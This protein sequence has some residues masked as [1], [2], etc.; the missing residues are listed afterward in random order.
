MYIDAIYNKDRD[1]V[2]IAERINGKRVMKDIPVEYT[3][4]YDDPNGSY[5]S[6]YGT[7][8]AKYVTRSAK[9][10][11]FEKRRLRMDGKHTYEADI[12][13]ELKILEQYYKEGDT[14]KPN[15]CFFDI[16]VDFCKKRGFAPTNDPFN[17]ITAI[18]AYNS[19]EKICYTVLLKP[20][21]MAESVAH[22]IASKFDNTMV[23]DDEEQLLTMFFGIIEDA[24]ILTGW[25]STAFDIPY[26][27]NRI[28]RI[29][30]SDHARELCLWGYQPKPRTFERFKKKQQT[31]DLVGR[32]HLDYLEDLYKKYTYHEQPS[33]KLDY[34]G[35]VEVGE[36][37]VDYKG[38]LDHLY[39]FDFEKFVQYSRQDV[40]LMVKIDDK[41]DHI[42]LVNQIAHDNLVR[43]QTVAGAVAL[44]DHAIVREI[45]SK[46]LVVRDKPM[47]T[48]SVFEIYDQD[49]ITSNI[50][51]EEL[52]EKLEQMNNTIA[53]AF[54]ADPKRGL[55]DW[56]GSTDINS[57]YPSVIRALN[58]SPETIFG[59]IDQPITRKHHI[60]IVVNEAEGKKNAEMAYAWSGKFGSQEFELMKEKSQ[61]K[62]H[63]DFED[64]TSY[65][66][67][68]DEIHSLVYDQGQPLCISANGTI[69]RTDIPGIIPGLLARWYNERVDMRKIGKSFG[70]M[71][72]GVKI[73]DENLLKQL[74][75]SL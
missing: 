2:H 58:M 9:K 61:H 5:N 41:L 75:E 69:F 64:G 24:D 51:E 35:E 27:V 4:Y 14:P 28:K 54:V 66:M 63:V 72:S 43:L 16:E 25:N 56:I 74:E 44:T 8:V 59:H 19:W 10:F 67:G 50:P 53:G 60:N 1:L 34:I 6:M 70:A 18:S 20:E 42:G 22:D 45:H 11:N 49:D 71:A 52:V 13:P 48:R 15:V 21:A 55:T 29:M 37:K 12:K 40:M 68:G 23:C 33:Y 3:L 26:V 7:K 57:L 17:K 73:K 30:T 32:I 47:D 36:K 38:T 65:N 46:N 39:N 31:Y 62:L